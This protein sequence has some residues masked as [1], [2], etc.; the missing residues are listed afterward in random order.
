MAL[1]DKILT[2]KR[3]KPDA[4][5]SVLEAEVDRLVTALR[6]L[7]PAEIQIVEEAGK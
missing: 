3:A 7:T 6:G 4:D 2:A 1:V 5:V